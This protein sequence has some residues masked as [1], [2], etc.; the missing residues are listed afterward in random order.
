MTIRTILFIAVSFLIALA[1]GMFVWMNHD[2]EQKQFQNFLEQR[3]QYFNSLFNAAL[4]NIALQMQQNAAYIASIPEVQ[5]VFSEGR[6]AVE[7]EGGGKGGL[8]AQMARCRLLSIVSKPWESL[9]RLYGTHQ[10]HFQFGLAATSFLRVHAPDEF[11]DDLADVRFMVQDALRSE[12]PIMGFECGRIIC[13]IRGVVPITAI[14]PD[15]PKRLLKIGVLE[16][17]TSYQSL[18]QLVEKS[19][20]ARFAVLLTLSHTRETIWPHHFATHLT[21]EPAIGNYF[22]ES[23]LHNETRYLLDHRCAQAVL[24]EHGVNWCRIDQRDLA[25]SAFPLRDYQG[26]KDPNRAAVGAILTWYDVSEEIAQLQHNFHTNILYALITF[27]LIES[28]LFIAFR[29]ATRKLKQAL[30]TQ[31][32]TLHEF[33]LRDQ[34]TNL[35]NRRYLTECLEK[36][37]KRV[38]RRSPANLSLALVDLDQFKSVNE[39]FGYVVGDQVLVETAHLISGRIR[40]SDYMFRYGGEEFLIIL[41]DTPL[42]A[43]V[44]LCEDLRQLLETSTI[45]TLS[46]GYIRASFGVTELTSSGATSIDQLLKYVDQALCQAKTKG[47]NRVDFVSNYLIK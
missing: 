3:A 30:N 24:H 35:Y 7:T 32:A 10:L 19:S 1:E 27:I 5:Q 11:G 36:E 28:V 38:Q 22:I 9:E 25:L 13:G 43:A 16:A 40:T 29:I 17:G 34:L 14:D 18:L 15:N 47:C 37:M 31:T 46:T 20:N 8:Q 12:K 26:Q 39:R 21:K 33:S 6:K 4:E 44:K 45:S 41:T 42:N 2:S 23:S